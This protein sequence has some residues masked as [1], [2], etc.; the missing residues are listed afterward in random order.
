MTY[1]K[2]ASLLI[3]LATNISCTKNLTLDQVGTK[4]NTEQTI[5]F[6]EEYI[7]QAFYDPSSIKGL[8]IKEPVYGKIFV[9]NYFPMPQKGWVICFQASAKNL[10]GSYT[11]IKK[12][13]IG[14]QNMELKPHGGIDVGW[15]NC[16]NANWLEK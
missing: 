7:T 6:V 1:L 15:Q 8:K 14:V 4:P 2:K 3:A 10:M 12:F 11:G 16:R 5:A 9:G 13:S